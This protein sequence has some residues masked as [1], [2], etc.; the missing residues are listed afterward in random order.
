ML[1]GW[2]WKINKE[3]ETDLGKH[4]KVMELICI[5]FLA[6]QLAWGWNPYN[7]SIVNNL[8][9]FNFTNFIFVY[10]VNKFKEVFF[11]NNVSYSQTYLTKHHNTRMHPVRTFVSMCV[12]SVCENNLCVGVR[13]PELYG[14]GM[15]NRR[16]A[17]F[18]DI[19]FVDMCLAY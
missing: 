7:W 4:R 3:M 2:T 18:Q 13:R 14:L 17:I 16:H 8:K 5:Y 15:F 19:C 11:M 9:A 1:K 10:N 12:H 6:S